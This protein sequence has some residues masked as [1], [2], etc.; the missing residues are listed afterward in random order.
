MEVACRNF[1]CAR[2]GARRRGGQDKEMSPR[3]ANMFAA[4]PVENGFSTRSAEIH[5]RDI[6]T[7]RVVSTRDGVPKK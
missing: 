5:N 1:R 6:R 3:H 4:H 7:A 2:R